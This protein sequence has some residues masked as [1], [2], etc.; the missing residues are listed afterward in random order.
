MSIDYSYIRLLFFFIC[1]LYG[2]GLECFMGYNPVHNEVMILHYD[3]LE[4]YN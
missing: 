1:F 2:R 4:Y 3:T